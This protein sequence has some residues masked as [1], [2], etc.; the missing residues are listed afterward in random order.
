MPELQALLTGL[1]FGESPRWHDGRLWFADW[2]TREIIAVDLD[3]NREV[4]LRVPTAGDV[5]HADLAGFDYGWNEL[6]VDGPATPISTAPASTSSP[7]RSSSLASLR[8]PP[9]TA[10]PARWPTGSPS[11]TAWR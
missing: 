5:S 6:V 10:R 7:A 2:G 4:V 1:S 9:P 11:R 3:G 8:W